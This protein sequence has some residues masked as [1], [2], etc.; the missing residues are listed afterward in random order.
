MTLGTSLPSNTSKT[1]PTLF[2]EDNQAA[3]AIAEA[4][5]S[6]LHEKTRAIGIREYFCRDC[7]ASGECRVIYVNSKQ[8]IADIMTKP[9]PRDTFCNLRDQIMG[10]SKVK[11]LS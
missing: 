3:I 5:V 11:F 4:P 2:F 7:I 6:R 9:L 8:N 1:T 10:Y